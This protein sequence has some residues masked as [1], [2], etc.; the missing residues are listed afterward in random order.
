MR[1]IGGWKK[2][3]A[4]KAALLAG[5]CVIAAGSAY[6]D[7]TYYWRSKPQVL[8]TSSAGEPQQGNLSISLDFSPAL[9]LTTDE[10]VNLTVS[11][12]GDEAG[13]Q[14]RPAASA[15]MAGLAVSSS[16]G[17]VSGTPS[18]TPGS[19]Y[20]IAVEAVRGGK[21]V[22]TSN[23][24]ERILR[25]PLSVVA[26]PDDLEFNA[27]EP[28]PLTGIGAQAAGGDLSSV[29]WSL[30]N[31]PSW[32]EIVPGAGSGDAVL[33]VKDGMEPVVTAQRTVTVVAT[34][35]ESREGSGTFNLSVLLDLGAPT[36]LHFAT[37]DQQAHGDL[38]LSE[39]RPVTGLAAPANLAMSNQSGS[40]QF[41]ICGDSECQHVKSEWSVALRAVANGDYVQVRAGVPIGDEDTISTSFV[42]GTNVGGWTVT[43][44]P[45][46]DVVSA[47]GV[48]PSS[49]TF[50]GGSYP[51]WRLYNGVEQIGP[52]M[53]NSEFVFD[54]GRLVS[55]SKYF[56]TKYQTGYNYP[57]SVLSIET[58]NG[59]V[60]VSTTENNGV[61]DIG[62]TVTAQRV[63]IVAKDNFLYE[64]RIGDGDGGGA[65]AAPVLN[66]TDLKAVAMIGPESQ[67]VPL[68]VVANADR[69]GDPAPLSFEI[70]AGQVPD[71]ASIDGAGV[72]HVP[73]ATQ[74]GE[75]PWAFTVK[76][77]DRYG[78]SSQ[79]QLTIAKAVRTAAEVYPVTFEVQGNTYTAV[80]GYYDNNPATAA[81]V[82]AGKTY[83]YNFAE[84][85]LVDRV[86]LY[87]HTA[88]KVE[89]QGYVNGNWVVLYT[90]GEGTKPVGYSVTTFDPA[91]VTKLMFT[92][93]SDVDSMVGDFYCGYLD[94]P[95]DRQY[96]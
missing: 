66:Y 20:K 85:V 50:G 49:A 53:G 13:V 2:G 73:A 10:T 82:S 58:P 4:W 63:K 6:G 5:A 25:A 76:V 95:P 89:L 40:F 28:F 32:L 19:A 1:F 48:F 92:N 69:Y 86:K 54:F 45:R 78:F 72:L 96:P 74:E 18:G 71:G 8:G 47:S 14:Y 93:K 80:A 3:S 75:G 88:V 64:L 68:S 67:E 46:N 56:V 15:N 35:A 11:A 57:A 29:Q 42:I 84:E 22:A 87:L 30:V 51:A 65:H 83:V 31:A 39:I 36:D 52:N 16:T 23:V 7:T 24:V 26:V 12:E 62:H 44:G 91:I 61:I 60:S 38:I 37:L 43:S 27:G 81:T 90:S 21:V 94:F 41:R 33:R 77:T 79:K 17:A 9:R 59:W 70:V 34:D 55:F